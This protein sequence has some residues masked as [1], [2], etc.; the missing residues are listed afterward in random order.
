[1]RSAIEI[2]SDRQ[3]FDPKVRRTARR[4]VTATPAS[5]KLMRRGRS[6]RR[7]AGVNRLSRSVLGVQPTPAAIPN[8]ALL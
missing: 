6:G 8:D 3:W 4:Q 7:P 1:M 2:D 5:P